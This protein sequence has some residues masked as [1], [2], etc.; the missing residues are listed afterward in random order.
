MPVAFSGTGKVIKKHYIESGRQKVN[1]AGHAKALSDEELVVDYIIIV[2]E[3]D[4]TD[5]V[6]VGAENVKAEAGKEKGIPLSAGGQL[7]TLYSVNLAEI[8]VDAVVD[9]EGVTYFYAY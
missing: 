3:S 8:Y 6:V 1:N 7:L 4:N 9:D 2:A 5:R